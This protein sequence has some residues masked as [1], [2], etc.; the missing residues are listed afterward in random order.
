MRHPSTRPWVPL[1]SYRWRVAPRRSSTSH[2]ASGDVLRQKSRSRQLFLEE[3]A[4]DCRMSRQ[5][6]PPIFHHLVLLDPVV[7]RPPT[8]AR[9][10]ENPRYFLGADTSPWILFPSR[11]MK[12]HN[13]EAD[14]PSSVVVAPVELLSPSLASTNHER[15]L[16]S[17]PRQVSATVMDSY[18]S[19]S[20]REG[21]G[22]RI[23]NVRHGGSEWKK[24]P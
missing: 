13:S 8:L 15:H 17:A 2:S 16:H 3:D 7:T 20:S 21:E 12:L 22:V 14:Y 9:R 11:P 4:A 1:P 24:L 19:S 23:P 18:C 5:A 6:Y 10:F